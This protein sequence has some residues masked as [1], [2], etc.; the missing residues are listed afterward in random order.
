MKSDWNVLKMEK[1]DLWIVMGNLV[2]V[3]NDQN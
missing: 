3:V 2:L 1:M